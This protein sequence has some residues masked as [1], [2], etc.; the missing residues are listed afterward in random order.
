MKNY[1]I[2][3]VTPHLPPD[4]GG[5]ANHVFNLN[6]NLVKLG[7]K[8]S[9]IAPKRITEQIT[10][11]E[12]NFD[13]VF[14]LSSIHLPGWPYPT[15]R[16]MSIPF[17]M[18]NEIQ[19]IIKN[20]NFDIIHVH[21]HHY[22]ISWIAI[23]AA[24]K[25]GIPCILTMH[26]MYALNPNVIDGRTKIE[27]YFNKYYFTKIL[28]KTTAVIGTTEIVINYAKKFGKDSIKY[29]KISNGV[30][31]IQFKENLKRKE[32]YRQKYN[33]GNDK[34]VIL[35]R[36]RFEHVKGVIEFAKAAIKIIKNKNIEIILL[37]GGPLESSVKEILNGIDRIHILGWQPLEQIHELYIASDIFVMP[38]RLEAQGITV[39]EAM[40]A[41]LHIVYSPIGGI[42]ETVEGYSAKTKLNE[43]S[44]NEIHKVLTDLISNF[45]KQNIVKSSYSNTQNFDWSH[46]ATETSKVYEACLK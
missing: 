20:G 17:L 8:V 7:N 5:I 44:V 23:N 19:T 25:F 34:L 42:P 3:T 39:I 18:G 27:D 37:G 11:L 28:A 31:T 4:S 15:M 10:E 35:F 6:I 13:Q 30:N 38:S 9:V 12:Q 32:E 33:I 21:G 29:F 46:I 26:G 43:V 36:G 1:K 16:S 14:R 24:H 22:P 2:L 40:Q 45:P 41:G